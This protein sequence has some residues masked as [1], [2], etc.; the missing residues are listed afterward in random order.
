LP[1][2]HQENAVCPEGKERKE[3]ETRSQ[4][5]GTAP[6]EDSCLARNPKTSSGALPG[7]FP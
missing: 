6:D 5:S 2:N 1:P 4:K 7:F 3:R